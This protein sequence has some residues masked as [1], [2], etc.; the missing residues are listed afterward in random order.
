MACNIDQFLDQKTPNNEPLRGKYMKSFGYHSLMHRMPDVFSAIT[1]LLK[2]KQFT[3]ANKE[4][5][6]DIVNK[7]ELLLSEILNNKPLRTIDSTSTLA[8]MWNQLL[9]KKFNSDSIVTWFD[10][11]WLF[12]ENYLYIRIKEIFEKTK[13]LKDYDPFEQLKYKAFDESEITMIAI[14]EFLNSQ[15][16][17]K[18]FDNKNLK[19]LFI[20][21]LKICL[22]GNRFDLSLNIG[23]SKNISEDPLEAI[24]SLDKYI[25]TDH[26][27]EIWNT[28]NVSYDK[29]PKIIDIILDNSAYELFTDMCLAHFFITYG[30]AETVV[31]HGKSIPWYVS[32]VTRP[33]FEHFLNR[34]VKECTSSALQQIGNRWNNYYKTGKFVIECEEFWTLPHC[35]STMATEDPEL[36]KKLA[37]SQLLIFKGDLNYR[38]LI[39]DINWSPSTTF[40]SALCRFQPTAVVALRTLK[41]D[42]VCDLDCDYE[43]KI[44][45]TDKNDNYLCSTNYWQ[46]NGKYAVVHLSK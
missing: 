12:T 21:I 30:F 34:L 46:V 24:V 9:E 38:K 8:L 40:K 15:F 10:T 7:L 42:C 1:G 26:S 19:I 39:G 16:S 5:I 41:C 14:A 11:E 18:E 44:D 17:K 45:E 3:L 6:N 28:L 31:F 27:D 37:C 35:Y 36:Y 20:Q 13:M 43:T 2:A 4:E 25:L 33:D 32:D 29:N 23:K 22:W